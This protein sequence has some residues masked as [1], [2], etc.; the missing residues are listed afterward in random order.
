MFDGRETLKTLNDPSSFES[1]LEFDLAHQA[2]DA[3]LGHAQATTAP[4]QQQLQEIVNF[5]LSTYTA[6]IVD[7]SA[8]QLTAQGADGGPSYLS[9]VQYYPGINDSLGA[10][11][12]PNVFTLF[13]SWENLMSNNPFAL[14]RASVARGEK[15]FNSAP[16]MIQNVKGLN[17]VLGMS[18]IVGTCSTCHDAPNVGDH[19]LSLPLDIGISD[20][21]TNSQD[22][23]ATALGELNLP[24]TPVYKLTC[25]TSLGAPSNMSIETT[26]PGRA[27]ITGLCAD[28]GK[29]KGPVLR[30]LAGHAPYFQNGA[31]DTLDQVVAF[32]NQRF[33]MGLT[34]NEMADLVN[35]LKSL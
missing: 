20:V 11:F 26:D 21:P 8:G 2:L 31:A 6:Q 9:S 34:A 28:I 1:N 35:F 10:T 3:T 22:S 16:L 4:T 17:D 33:Q 7:N 25:S 30:G 13:T 32:Y 15:I 23:L 12:N 29:F 14:G 24:L 5:E 18:T 19:S 27:L